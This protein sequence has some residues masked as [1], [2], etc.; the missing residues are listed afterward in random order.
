MENANVSVLHQSKEVAAFQNRI[1]YSTIPYSINNYCV[2]GKGREQKRRRQQSVDHSLVT[3]RISQQ[4][5]RQT[6]PVKYI[7]QYFK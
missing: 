6:F 3:F 5:G 1:D 7:H 2:E 4:I